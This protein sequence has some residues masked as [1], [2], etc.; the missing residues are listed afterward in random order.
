LL[1]I[2][3]VVFFSLCW[4]SFLAS[5]SYRI[6]YEKSILQKRS[7]CPLCGNI[8][9]WY[10]NIPLFSW[11]FLRG[12]CFY[13]KQKISFIYP[14][15]ELL[16]TVSFT[17]LW[18]SFNRYDAFFLSEQIMWL[19]FFSYALFFSALICATATDL[20]GMVIPQLFSLWL[21]PAGVILSSFGL[22]HVGCLE[23]VIGAVV[24]Y[25][26]L[27]FI[28]FVF[29]KLMK[30]DGLGEGDAELLG[31]IGAFIG[32]IGVYWTMF[33]ASVVGLFV[34]SLYLFIFKKGRFTQI[35][36]GP[37]LAI[38]AIVFVLFRREFLIFI[39]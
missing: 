2:V 35:P 4:G 34:G 20:W 21:I 31:M 27:R 29:K 24:G 12:K 17:Y 14:M 30:K 11:A 13:C 8:V 3:Y 26:F 39:M 15:I 22:I 25:G 7:Y 6:L 36:F 19:K 5:F 9:P 16:T 28:A 18:I 38:G 1:E 10:C 23:S 37:F 33:L 32:P